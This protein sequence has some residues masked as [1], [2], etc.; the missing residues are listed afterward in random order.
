MKQRTRRF[1]TILIGILVLCTFSVLAEEIVFPDLA[2]H[3][4]IQ[5]ALGMEEEHPIQLED[6]E[7][8]TTLLAGAK[9]I[10]DLTG[11][12]MCDRLEQLHLY[13]NQI[14]NLESLTGLQALKNVSLSGNRIVDINP[15][16]SLRNLTS[17]AIHS[18]Q[19]AD[20]SPIA[21]LP[22]LAS[23]S[24]GNSI[25]DIEPLANLP[26]LVRLMVYVRPIT[27]LSP[28]Q[29][30]HHLESLFISTGQPVSGR[31]SF[32][33]ALLMFCSEL[34]SLQLHGYDI[35]RIADLADSVPTLTELALHYVGVDDLSMFQL[36]GGLTNL[37]LNGVI[38]SSEGAE[39][40][41]LEIPSGVKAMALENNEISDTASIAKFVSLTSLSLA[42]NRVTS[43]EALRGLKNLVV[44]DLSF[45][46]IA[47]LEPLRALLALKS[48]SLQGVPFD[49]TEGSGANILIRELRDRGVNIY[50]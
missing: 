1:R 23:L 45:N 41:H 17:L 5:A 7:L 21:S 39:F 26:S 8:L 18:N 31:I 9:G 3:A 48:L 49:Q 10:V 28:L 14:I 24:I 13:S 6:L 11:M 25:D 42:R 36:I 22:L 32:D 20:I 33:P 29:K 12:E 37:T 43:I 2:L 44:L 27:D 47:D 34:T 50:Y 19:I 15:L 16:A 30:M 40:S 46:P 38:P 35:A 4:A